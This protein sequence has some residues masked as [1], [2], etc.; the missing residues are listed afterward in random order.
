M[1]TIETRFLGPNDHRGSRYKAIASGGM[2]LTIESDDALNSDQ[3]HARAAR[4]LI[5]KLGWFHEPARGDRYGEW[6]SGGRK[7][8]SV[9]WVCCVEYARLD[10]HG[11]A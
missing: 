3:N 5:R 9:V 8:G 4:A 6:F 1:Q 10:P 11:P 2:S 7:A